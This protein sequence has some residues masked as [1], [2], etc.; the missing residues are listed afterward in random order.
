M[1][2]TS[3]SP[4]ASASSA[5]VLDANKD[6]P[7]HALRAGDAAAAAG[8]H[9]RHVA[10]HR[11]LSQGLQDGQ[12]HQPAHAARSSTASSK[13]SSSATPANSRSASRSTSGR[14][15]GGS[16]P[17]TWPRS[18]R[19]T[20]PAFAWLSDQAV[21]VGRPRCGRP[22]QPANPARSAAEAGS[23]VT[24]HAEA[25]DGEHA[26][27][28][29]LLLRN[30]LHPGRPMLVTYMMSRFLPPNITLVRLRTRARS[31]GRCCHPAHSV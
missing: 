3:T 22:D 11:T 28:G 1:E 26:T 21:Q 15:P 24:L 7:F 6:V 16:S 27:G 4:E 14:R 10:A 29:S 23:G 8:D 20:S 9:Q 13:R 5:D 12:H 18:W 30:A 17:T 19:T 31:R 25:M 2:S